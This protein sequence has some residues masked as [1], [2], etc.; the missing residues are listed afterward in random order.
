MLS[1]LCYQDARDSKARGGAR[2]KD[3]GKNTMGDL[4]RDP[5]ETI[6]QLG[7]TMQSLKDRLENLEEIGRAHV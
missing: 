5:T 6:E 3:Y 2:R 4:P 7:K 1:S